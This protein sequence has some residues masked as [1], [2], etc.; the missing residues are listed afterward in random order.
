[1][2]VNIETMAGGAMSEKFNQ[3]FRKVIENIQDPNTDDK[4]ARKITLTL[5]ISPTGHRSVG[6]MKIDA[7]SALVPA[8]GVETTFSM[9]KDLETG[10]VQAIEIG[11][12]V[13]GQLEMSLPQEEYQ[14]AETI[15]TVDPSTGEIYETPVNKVI[16]LRER[17]A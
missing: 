2:H 7:K 11:N 10:E 1:M 16:N 5:T 15:Q 4:K 9:G 13:P 8:L 12:Q 17:K 6:N 3:E 14:E